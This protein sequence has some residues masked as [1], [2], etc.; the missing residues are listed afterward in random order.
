MLFAAAESRLAGHRTF[1]ESPVC[2]SHIV[3]GALGLQMCIIAVHFGS[4]IQTQVFALMQPAF[5]P[6]FPALQMIFFNYKKQ[7]CYLSENKY[8]QS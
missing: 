2:S 1:E 7:L 4:G 8:N 5:L 6:I 3:V